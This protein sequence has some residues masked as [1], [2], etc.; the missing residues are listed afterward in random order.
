MQELRWGLLDAAVTLETLEVYG[1]RFE[2]FQHWCSFVHP[3]Y[4]VFD[5]TENHDVH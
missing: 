5:P 2:K 1:K 4:D 3:D